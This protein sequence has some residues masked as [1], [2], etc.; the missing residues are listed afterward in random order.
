MVLAGEDLLAQ[1]AR[2]DLDAAD[3][4]EDLIGFHGAGGYGTSTVLRTVLM[5]SVVVMFSASAS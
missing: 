3:L 5:M 1:R 2:L 4:L